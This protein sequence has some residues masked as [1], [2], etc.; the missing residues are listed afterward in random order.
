MIINTSIVKAD[1]LVSF[2]DADTPTVSYWIYN[3]YLLY[4][5]WGALYISKLSNIR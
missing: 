5:M 1:E 3:I 4:K 2:E